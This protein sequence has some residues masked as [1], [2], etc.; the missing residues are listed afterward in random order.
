MLT[1]PLVLHSANDHP[2]RPDIT[3]PLLPRRMATTPPPRRRDSAAQDRLCES[4][5]V[6]HPT[7]P[8]PKSSVAG[9]LGSLLGD[10]LR[11]IVSTSDLPDGPPSRHPAA[12]MPAATQQTPA[13]FAAPAPMAA[14]P[15]MGSPAA[16]AAATPS[17]PSFRPGAIET[18]APPPQQSGSNLGRS[19]LPD[20]A[21]AVSKGSSASGAA[22]AAAGADSKDPGSDAKEKAAPSPRAR[23][24][25]GGAAATAQAGWFAKKMNKWLHPD[26]KQVQEGLGNSMEAYFDKDKNR[27]VFPDED[28]GA[29]DDAPP[30][31]PPT[32]PIPTQAAEPQAGLASSEAYQSVM[33]SAVESMHIAMQAVRQADEARDEALSARRDLAVM[34]DVVKQSAS[35]IVMLGVQVVKADE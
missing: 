32:G 31:A 29:E 11:R 17:A 35:V 21:P 5:G 20:P 1:V 15:A 33:S 16:A 24:P 30:L 8:G 13:P 26:A 25:G 19:A 28:G 4:L 6:E 7:V 10:G 12:A 23:T 14:G 18:Q 22:D 9:M 34:A 2:R 3:T 27:W